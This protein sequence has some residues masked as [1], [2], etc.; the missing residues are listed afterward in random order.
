MQHQIDYNLPDDV[1]KR[2]EPDMSLTSYVVPEDAPKTPT[3]KEVLAEL[4]NDVEGLQSVTGATRGN[5]LEGKGTTNDKPA[6]AE[7][8]IEPS[9]M[10]DTPAPEGAIPYANWAAGRF[11]KQLTLEKFKKRYSQVNPAKAQSP[12]AES[13]KAKTKKRAR[14]YEEDS[15]GTEEGDDG[16]YDPKKSSK[17]LRRMSKSVGA[18]GKRKSAKKAKGW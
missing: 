14:P 11:N 9:E 16:G 4:A 10:G 12:Q 8:D 5:T 7:S 1:I 6:P 15:S 18:G 13:P 2:Y 17:R 3:D